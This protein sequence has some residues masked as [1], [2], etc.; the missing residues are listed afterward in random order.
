MSTVTKVVNEMDK[1]VFLYF[2]MNKVPNYRF[3]NFS[4]IDL[5]GALLPTQVRVFTNNGVKTGSGLGGR[6]SGSAT[7]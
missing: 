7:D 1:Y 4:K 6:K 2:C 3:K 5:K